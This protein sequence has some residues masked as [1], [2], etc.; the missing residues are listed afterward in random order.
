MNQF[1]A[2]KKFEV[3]ESVS[4]VLDD[5]IDLTRST[6]VFTYMYTQ[7]FFFRQCHELF[8]DLEP[9]IREVSIQFDALIDYDSWRL[10]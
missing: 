3:I 5:T 6:Q 7:S 1:Y 4:V 2:A 8:K 10:R 9:S